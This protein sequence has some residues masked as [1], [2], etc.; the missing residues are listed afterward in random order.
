M[1]I[2]CE[3]SADT[4]HQNKAIYVVDIVFLWNKNPNPFRTK[5]LTTIILRNC[6]TFLTADGMKY[7]KYIFDVRHSTVYT[8]NVIIT[9]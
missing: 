6:I 4:A 2:S 3:I 7:E 9:D 8:H 1:F 5:A